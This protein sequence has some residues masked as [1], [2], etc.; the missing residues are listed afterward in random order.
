MR[1]ADIVFVLTASQDLYYN[2][3]TAVI[4]KSTPP[5]VNE[6]FPYEGMAARDNTSPAPRCV[7]T[8][9]NGEAQVIRRKWMLCE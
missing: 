5:R 4:G 1:H 6:S 8:H 7:E 2:E 3:S 9:F